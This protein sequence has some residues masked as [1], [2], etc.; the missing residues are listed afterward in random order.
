MGH[1]FTRFSGQQTPEVS[2]RPCPYWAIP[3]QLPIDAQCQLAQNTSCW[4]GINAPP[5]VS[6]F[7]PSEGF[8]PAMEV[9]GPKMGLGSAGPPTLPIPIPTC[10]Q[11][12][13]PARA[14]GYSRRL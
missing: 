7:Q 1:N 12:Q 2:V 13:P 5:L 3:E 10:G 4:P 8:A 14:R 6:Y 9:A 11:T